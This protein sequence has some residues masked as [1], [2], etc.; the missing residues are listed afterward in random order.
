MVILRFSC[1][2]SFGFRPVSGSVF[3]W[4]WTCAQK[5]HCRQRRLRRYGEDIP[6]E[7]LAERLGL[8]VHAY[9]L[10]AAQAAGGGIGMGS[11]GTVVPVVSM[12]KLY[13]SM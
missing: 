8:F 11:N 1:G 12:H 10:C 13:V 4:G 2:F 5:P 3:L 7:V 6:A 9:T